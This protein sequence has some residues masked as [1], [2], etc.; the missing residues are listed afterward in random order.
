MVIWDLRLRRQGRHQRDTLDQQLKKS[1]KLLMATLDQ[2]LT[3]FQKYQ[4]QH[5]PQLLKL[6]SSRKQKMLMLDTLPPETATLLYQL[7]QC[8][9]LRPRPLILQLNQVSEFQML[10]QTSEPLPNQN[11][12]PSS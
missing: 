1:E 4:F 12:L 6:W 3:S 9:W 2:L 11:R 5:Q 8:L 7:H 10:Q